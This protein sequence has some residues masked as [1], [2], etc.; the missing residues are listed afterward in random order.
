MWS[1][2]LHLHRSFPHK[3]LLNTSG[4]TTNEAV[5]SLRLPELPKPARL[6]GRSQWYALHLPS[7]GHPRAASVQP[8]PGRQ[9]RSPLVLTLVGIHSLTLDSG[10]QRPQKGACRDLWSDALRLEDL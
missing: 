6:W 2:R 5:H 8:S 10:V 7:Q 9:R 3:P 1:C 4:E